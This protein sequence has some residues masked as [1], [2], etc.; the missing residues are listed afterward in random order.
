MKMASSTIQ[1]VNDYP[2]A[3]S[4]ASRRSFLSKTLTAATGSVAIA[5]TAPM[6]AIAVDEEPSVQTPLYYILRVREATVQETRL[7]NSGKFKDVQ[8]ADVKVSDY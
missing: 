4:I 1:D 7:I 3:S 6:G 5:T 2:S 8:R